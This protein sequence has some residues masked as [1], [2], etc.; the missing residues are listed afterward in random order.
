[1]HLGSRRQI[2]LHDD[3]HHGNPRATTGSDEGRR[4][5]GSPTPAATCMTAR[6]E[7]HPRSLTGSVDEH[8]VDAVTGG[9]FDGLR[10]HLQR[11]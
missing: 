5:A 1:M 2:W 7:S 9:G 8:D 3:G 11:C 4:H 10:G 6:F